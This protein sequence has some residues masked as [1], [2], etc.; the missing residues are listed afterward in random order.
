MLAAGKFDHLTRRTLSVLKLL[1][2]Q[3]IDNG[4]LHINPAQGVRVIRT[5]RIQ[6]KVPVPSKETVRKLIDAADEDFKPMLIV[7]A[8]CGLRASELR[9]LRWVDIDYENGFIRLGARRARCSPI[10]CFR[11]QV[12]LICRTL[13]PSRLATPYCTRR[14]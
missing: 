3:A 1:L 12:T 2:N 11:S 13:T 10:G 8:L 9:G 4:H 7:S 5:G 6:Y 14:P